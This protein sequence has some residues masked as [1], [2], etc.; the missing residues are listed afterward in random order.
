MV[1]AYGNL[2]AQI[3]FSGGRFSS[4]GRL[5]ALTVTDL[6]TGD[7]D[8]VW[9]Y[10]LSSHRLVPVIEKCPALFRITDTIWA[11]NDTL[12]VRAEGPRKRYWA[13]TMSHVEEKV[14][15]PLDVVQ[16]FEQQP[17]VPE[18]RYENTQ[19]VRRENAQ[20]SVWVHR[21]GHGFNSLRVSRK[22]GTDERELVAGSWE[23]ESYIFDAQ[24]SMVLY[25]A[26]GGEAGIAVEDLKSGSSAGG[27]SLPNSHRLRLLDQTRDARV[28][29]YVVSG[30]CVVS[31][32]STTDHPRTV[33][34]ATR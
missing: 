8:G 27:L 12:Y 14:P 26:G 19:Y 20:Y 2:F 31:S 21:G 18:F 9:L 22:G 13:A 28:I 10:E 3:N 33:C 5:L 25:P 6:W 17:S 34:L 32:D 4:D 15:V 16:T 1:A 7:T 29:A 30:S 23:L 11:N 24:R